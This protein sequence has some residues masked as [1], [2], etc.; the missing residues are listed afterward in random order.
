MQLI[1]SGVIPHS[2]ITKLLMERRLECDECNNP[3]WPIDA[4]KINGR[5]PDPINNLGHP[6]LSPTLEK[7]EWS[8][9]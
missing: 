8:L 2:A 1:A 5:I 9:A 6:V 7:K 4:K 3:F